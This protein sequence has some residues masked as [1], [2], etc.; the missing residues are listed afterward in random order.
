MSAIAVRGQNLWLS[1]NDSQSILRGVDIAAGSGQ[2]YGLVGPSGCGKTTLQRCVWGFYK[3]NSGKILVFGQEPGSLGCNIPGHDLGYMPQDDSLDSGLTVAETLSF[4]QMCHDRKNLPIDEQVQELLTIVNIEDPKKLVRELS[5]GQRRRLSFACACLGFPKLLL[6]DEPTV[7]SD[8]LARKNV[9]MYL[10]KLQHTHDIT[11]IIT[12]HYTQEI[13]GADRMGLMIRGQIIYEGPPKCL[14]SSYVQG[15]LEASILRFMTDRKNLPYS[16]RSTLMSQRN[17]FRCLPNTHLEISIKKNRPSYAALLNRVYSII[18]K[19]L[20]VEVTAALLWIMILLTV[21]RTIS[22]GLK[23]FG[24][25]FY[26]PFNS[27]GAKLI[28]DQ[29]PRDLV[30]RIEV[31]S[32]HDGLDLLQKNKVAGF[33]NFA[34]E[35]SLKLSSRVNCLIKNQDCDMAGSSIGTYYLDRADV[36]ASVFM[37]KLIENSIQNVTRMKSFNISGNSRSAEFFGMAN[38]LSFQHSL[39]ISSQSFVWKFF[40]YIC[41]LNTAAI[42]IPFTQDDR[43]RKRI[44]KFLSMGFT[45]F[46]IITSYPIVLT[47][48]MIIQNWVIMFVGVHLSDLPHGGQYFSLGF[49]ITCQTICGVLV[50]LIISLLFTD[51][52]KAFLLSVVYVFSASFLGSTIWP[53]EAMPFFLSNAW[54]L[55]PYGRMSEIAISLAMKNMSIFNFQSV[56]ILSIVA[57]NIASYLFISLIMIKYITFN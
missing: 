55:F 5:G 56:E 37:D 45:R 34:G 21:N 22:D 12:T 29:M 16:T 48:I 11:V 47:F 50:S 32:E 13:A 38:E 40:F 20:W 31:Y 18:R 42:L 24:L 43:R 17:S 15:D 19:L 44:E 10:E 2:I 54:Y 57:L 28:I 30:E 9:W 8:P 3:L 39:K 1:I 53:H 27:S 23:G 41:V 6:L 51:S 25:A 35:I 26:N 36:Y 49:L 46:Q 33:I 7:G 4:F 14:E 52:S